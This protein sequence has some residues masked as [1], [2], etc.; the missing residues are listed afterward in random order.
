MLMQLTALELA[1]H[2][3]DERDRLNMELSQGVYIA[4]GERIMK[5]FIS[6]PHGYYAVFLKTANGELLYP[7]NLAPFKQ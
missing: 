3:I 6:N 1:P 7:A 5:A 2:L 4:H